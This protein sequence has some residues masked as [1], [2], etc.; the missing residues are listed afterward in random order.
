MYKKEGGHTGGRQELKRLA[1]EGKRL[2]RDVFQGLLLVA[3]GEPL[4]GGWTH[5]HNLTDQ[6]YTTL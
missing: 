4:G 5:V 3:C 6:L 1:G 2:G